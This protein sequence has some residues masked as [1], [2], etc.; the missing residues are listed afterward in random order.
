MDKEKEEREQSE[1]KEFTNNSLKFVEELQF[2]L[3][4]DDVNSIK[5]LIDLAKSHATT[6]E[7]H[8][9]LRHLARRLKQ[10]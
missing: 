10:F 1:L 8:R 2:D 7:E 4:A 5:I 3:G 9:A 6:D